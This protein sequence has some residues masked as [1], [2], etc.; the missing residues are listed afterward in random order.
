VENLE[1]K[2]AKLREELESAKTENRNNQML[3]PSGQKESSE[4]SSKFEEFE[5]NIKILNETISLM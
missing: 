5:E 2:N 1:A 3:K 4:S